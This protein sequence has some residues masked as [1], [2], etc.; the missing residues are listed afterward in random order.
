M[1]IS[2][3]TQKAFYEGPRSEKLPLVVNDVV[4]VKDGR[5]AGARAWVIQIEQ[6]DPE[7]KYRIEYDDGSDETLPLSNLQWK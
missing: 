6:E 7:P 5:R 1:M 2:D 3:A 4:A